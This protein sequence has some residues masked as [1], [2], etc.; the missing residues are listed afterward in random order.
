MDDRPRAT[1]LIGRDAEYASLWREFELAAGGQ[2]RVA[3]VSGEP[4][5]GKTHLLDTVAAGAERRGA[6][7]LRGGAS[8][9]EGMPPYLPFLESLG[10]HIRRAEVR[11]L[12]AQTGALAAILTTL[13]PEL[14]L[15]LGNL[16]SSYPL[17]PDQARLRLYE[18]VG[19]FV[20]GIASDRPLLLILDDLQWADAATL[21][22]LC[23]IARYQPAIRLL[24]LGA[25]RS[26]EIYENQ[27]LSRTVRELNRQRVLRSI[28]LRSITLEETASLAADSL[29][30]PLDEAGSVLL[31]RQS[32]GNPFF[33]EELLRGWIDSHALTLVET[34]DNG[35]QFRVDPAT[36]AIMPAGILGAV[37]ERLDR[38]SQPVVETLRTAAIIGREFDAELLTTVAGEAH[39]V[40]EDRLQTAMRANVIQTLADQGY[41]FTHDK[42]RECLYQDVGPY[43]RQRL[44]G[45]IGHAL[46]AQATQ[47]DARL[48]ADLAYH[49]SR[50]GDRTKGSG[51]AERAARQ[52][53]EAYAA[54]DA[55]AHYQTALRLMST[56]D[57]H[58]AAVLIGLGE[59]ASLAGDER[60][61]VEAYAPACDWFEA[62]GDHL[63][64]GKASLYL[65]RAHWRQEA[66]A[67][68]RA[69]LERA[70]SLLASQPGPELVETLVDLGSLLAV[71][72]HELDAGIK[73]ARE[74]LHMAEMLE[75]ERLLAASN[76]ALGNLLV[77]AN[78][79]P[80]GIPLLE[81]ALHLALGV[82]DLSEAAECCAG[83]ANAYC[84]QGRIDR[85]REV[86]MQR[87]ELAKRC[88]DHY[89]LRHVHTWLAVLAGYQG[90]FDELRRQ[91]D[92]AERIVSTLSSP[93]PR[94]YLEFCRAA[95]AY[96][97][98]DYREAE[99]RARTAQES[100]RAIG[101]NA[102]VWY[103]GMF[104]VIYVKQNRVSE[105]WEMLRELETL[106]SALPPG[107]MP[108]AESLVYMTETAIAFNDMDRLDRYYTRLLS[109]EGQIHDMSIDRLLGQIETLRGN[110][111]QAD[112]HLRA[113]EMVTR[114]ERMI[115]EEGQVLEARADLALAIGD[116]EHVR[117]A[118]AYL[119]QALACIPPELNATE[120]RRLRARIENL[121]GKTAS[122]RRRPNG[123]SPREAE[124]L[125]LVASG[126]SNRQI[127]DTLFI[128]EKT[129][130]NHLTHIFNKIGVDN[131]AAAAAFAVRHD[132][133]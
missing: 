102:M 99:N 62:A 96:Y 50:S 120:H 115:Q 122:D 131:R 110:F 29:G 7:A 117:V 21:D 2:T 4:G 71:S 133:A 3:F 16:Q 31:F 25:I 90:R 84:W 15:K 97:T 130:I 75:D 114:R 69:A 77:R 19:A 11:E 53:M 5:I 85:S 63:S 64:A 73:L 10:H 92:I 36:A 52:A 26:G 121:Q 76:R 30:A 118:L 32:E 129:V 126:L 67:Q 78:D 6:R 14:A 125:G 124:V 44:H 108:T 109:F 116:Q 79:L 33:I 22:L 70:R 35:G 34:R 82:D 80:A 49:Y 38:L 72:Q 24:M 59:A 43:R 23:A 51:Y 17:P 98:G 47:M 105:A 8:E 40:L 20:A 106:Q 89:Q 12:Q 55:T 119:E 18:A 91:L 74:A 113:A 37:R 95:E 94:A 61:A 56:Q 54:V 65:G 107:T 45:L 83:L 123:L 9:A 41:R 127:A 1:R 81:N 60:Q 28:E 86:T 132:L 128:S 13:F 39:D 104:M 93:E 48:L 103:M 111:A 66:I 58:W 57:A 42:I 101:P 87:L 88:H 100:F 46:E 27:P 68:A 112:S